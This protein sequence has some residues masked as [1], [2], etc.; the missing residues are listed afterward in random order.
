V[1]I[2]RLFCLHPCRWNVARFAAHDAVPGNAI[3][4]TGCDALN[5]YARRVFS[6]F[7]CHLWLQHTRICLQQPSRNQS[8]HRECLDFT[9]LLPSVQLQTSCQH[10]ILAYSELRRKMALQALHCVA[11][12]F[13]TPDR[14]HAS[15]RT[16]VQLDTRAC[17]HAHVHG[18][19]ILTADTVL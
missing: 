18:L 6:K 7:K 12:L 3:M 8:S 5:C 4:I 13:N 2:L 1:Y 14:D 15:A 16:V 19:L 17:G 9:L 11:L 10:H